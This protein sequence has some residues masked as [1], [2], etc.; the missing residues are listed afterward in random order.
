M[1]HYAV[2]GIERLRQYAHEKEDREHCLE[3]KL[4]ENWNLGVASTSV[5][6]WEGLD[7]GKIRN[8][9]RQPNQK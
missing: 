8:Y 5:W 9:Q 6:P 3:V 7:I 4:L 1:S 2:F